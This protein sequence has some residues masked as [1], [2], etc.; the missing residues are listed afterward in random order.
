MRLIVLSS[1]ACVTLPHFSHYLINETIF[2]KRKLLYMKRVVG[3]SLQLLSEIFLI[4]RTL[5]NDVTIN[6]HR[7]SSKLPVILVR[8]LSKFNFI[9]SF[10]KN[11]EMLHFMK[12]CPAGAE[13]FHV[14]RHDETNSHFSQ[15]FEGA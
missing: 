4:L 9:D 12:I 1:V 6:V 13:S 15:Y 10:S 2:E 14:D 11:P 8:F 7:S 3:F 5:Q